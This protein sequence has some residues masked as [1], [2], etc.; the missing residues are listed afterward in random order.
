MELSK[1]G[2]SAPVSAEQAP[3]H[4]GDPISYRPHTMPSACILGLLHPP[5]HPP[6]TWAH[7]LAAQHDLG[8]LAQQAALGGLNHAL[9]LCRRCMWGERAAVE[10]QQSAQQAASM[11]LHQQHLQHSRDA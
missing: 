10:G 4:P 1:C 6:P 8:Q 9:H 3:P 2:G 5:T 11:H 7:Q